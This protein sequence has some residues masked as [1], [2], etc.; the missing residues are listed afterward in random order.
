MYTNKFELANNNVIDVIIMKKN[1]IVPISV[2][3]SSGIFL[4]NF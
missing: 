1:R 3:Q 4:Q 2:N